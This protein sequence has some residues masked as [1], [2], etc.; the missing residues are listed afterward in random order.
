[1]D[2]A[3]RSKKSSFPKMTTRSRG[4]EKVTELVLKLLALHGVLF[5]HGQKITQPLGQTPARWQV[6][7]AIETQELTVSQIARRMGVTRQ[8]TQRTADILKEEGLVDFIENPDHIKS[9]KIKLTAAGVRVLKTIN[10][11][12]A[13]WA[14]QIA[15]QIS[16]D[17]TTIACAIL[18]RFLIALNKIELSL[19]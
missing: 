9:P 5:S 18:D 17:D 16:L 15:R 2:K 4:G 6:L 19:F 1:L 10:A 11:K 7:G 8:G 12:Q 14:N 13:E 3:K